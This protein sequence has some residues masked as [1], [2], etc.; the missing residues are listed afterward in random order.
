MA[1][2]YYHVV[3][4]FYSWLWWGWL[5]V[6]TDY[7]C[8]FDV[9]ESVDCTVLVQYWYST[10]TTTLIMFCKKMRITTWKFGEMKGGGLG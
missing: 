7:Y 4:P 9:V 8:S 5:F 3:V 10:G 6:F 2:Y 1:C